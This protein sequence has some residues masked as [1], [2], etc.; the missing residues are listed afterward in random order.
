MV[1]Q[2]IKPF[3]S[4]AMVY[5]TIKR[6]RGTG[7]ID[8]KKRKSYSHPLSTRGLINK[9]KYR[10]LK[11]SKK[12]INKMAS[13]LGF[14]HPTQHCIVKQDLGLRAYKL[15]KLQGLTGLLKEKRLKRSKVLLKWFANSKLTKLS[16][17][18]KNFSA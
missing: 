3:V 9:V 1:K 16:L 15:R 7:T 11:N 17:Q 5:R 13:D 18:M 8:C 14:S 4:R 2:F 10:L 6:L 12:S